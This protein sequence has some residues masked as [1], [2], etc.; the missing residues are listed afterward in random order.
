MTYEDFE[1][2]VE[3]GAPITLYLIT[4]GNGADDHFAFTNADEDQTYQGIVYEPVPVTR[5]AIQAT[6][7]LENVSFRASIDPAAA[8]VE[9]LSER[10]PTQ[11][12]RMVVR[13]GHVGDEDGEFQV[14]WTGKLTGSQRKGNL[15]ELT[16][17]L[18][19]ASLSRPG[20]KRQYQRG[21]SWALYEPHC[22]AARTVR[23]SP[24]PNSI[25]ANLVVLT[26]GWNGSLDREK[27]KGGYISWVS[28]ALGGTHRRTIL[29]VLDH[30]DGEVLLL[31]GNTD[32]LG[33]GTAIGIFAGCDHTPEDCRE[34][35]NNIRNYGGQWNIPLE[36][37]VGN[38]N[39]F[40]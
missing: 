2:S 34:L 5:E 26:L 23:A 40:F 10:T 6:G 14:I 7:N 4:Y 20:L 33:V 22:N 17:E 8:I 3:Q 27:F 30:T 28:A 29:D 35:H 37:P 24:T 38:R 11:E 16:G 13:E 15:V 18:I 32:G 12:V 31:Q 19:V 21:C 1:S 9:Y 39:T 36:N 25:G